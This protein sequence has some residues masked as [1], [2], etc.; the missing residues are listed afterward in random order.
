MTMKDRYLNIWMNLNFLLR[1]QVLKDRKDSFRK[2]TNLT[3]AH[4]SE[5]ESLRK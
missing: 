2:W 1:Q 3:A 5:A 4:T